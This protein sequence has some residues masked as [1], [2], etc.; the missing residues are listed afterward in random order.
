MLER[1]RVVITL[2]TVVVLVTVSC[3]YI[4]LIY[5]N[6]SDQLWNV[7]SQQCVPG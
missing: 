4:L 3:A 2:V 5:L 7:V 6:N 1:R